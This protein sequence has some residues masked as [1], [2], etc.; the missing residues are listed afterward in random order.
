MPTAFPHLNR[1]GTLHLAAGTP[2]SR[3]ASKSQPMSQIAI[4]LRDPTQA[5]VVAKP[6]WMVKT[7]FK[8]EFA[9]KPGPQP[10]TPNDP[11]AAS[12]S[13]PS[14]FSVHQKLG[15]ES[16]PAKTKRAVFVVDQL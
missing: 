9:F 10:A 1:H 15:L 11:A 4:M 5:K 13:A 2:L 6:D 3:I 16:I 8:L 14:I 12:P 7:I